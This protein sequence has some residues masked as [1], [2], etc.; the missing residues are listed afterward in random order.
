MIPKRAELVFYGEV[1]EE[2]LSRWDSTLR[3]PGHSIHP[4]GAILKQ[5]MP[6]DCGG[7]GHVVRHVNQNTVAPIYSHHRTRIFLIDDQDLTQNT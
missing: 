6:V 7:V 1:V 5:A 4:V 3:D 2:A